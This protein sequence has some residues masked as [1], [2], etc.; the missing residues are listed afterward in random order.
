MEL[1][2]ILKAGAVL[3]GLGFAFGGL[4]AAANRRLKVWEDPRIN[5]T[6][7]LL[8]GTNCGACGSPGCRGFAERLVAGEAEPAGC[9]QVDEEQVTAVAEY[10]GVDAGEAVKRIARLLCAGG[11]DVAKHHGDYTGAKTCASAAAA[12]GGAKACSWGCIGLADC[13]VVCDY[14]AIHMNQ[15]GLPVVDPAK[16]TACNDCVVACPK[17]LFVIMPVDQPL[18][19][20]CK[21]LME[22]EAA[23][24]TC[25]VACTGCGKC[26]MDS[27]PDAI[28]IIDGLAVVN[29]DQGVHVSPKATERCPT[30]AIKWIEWEQF[31]DTQLPSFTPKGAE[32]MGAIKV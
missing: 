21:S 3:G 15:F 20:Q 29:Y 13:A 5:A 23:E 24:E 14:D 11:T 18:L 8:P 10:L 12:G 17:D 27:D 25:K 22:G 31:T 19:V 7:D 9:T 26:A 1:D 16:C 6:V 30:G 4:I 28:S 32:H 2:T